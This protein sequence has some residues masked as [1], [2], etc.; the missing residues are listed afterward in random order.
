VAQI[1]IALTSHH[2]GRAVS[3]RLA[4]FTTAEA[5]QLTAIDEFHDT[6]NANTSRQA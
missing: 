6:L 4:L 1:D 5:W 3:S 2:T